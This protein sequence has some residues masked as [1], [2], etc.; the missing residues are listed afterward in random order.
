MVIL[1]LVSVL[2]RVRLKGVFRFFFR[3]LVLKVFSSLTSLK[4]LNLKHLKTFF[5][6]PVFLLSLNPKR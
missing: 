3:I 5:V 2:A 4:W 6:K 1:L